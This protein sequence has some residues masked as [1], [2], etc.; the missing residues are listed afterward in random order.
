[1]SDDAESCRAIGL[2]EFVGHRPAIETDAKAVVRQY[3]VH[4]GKG[5]LQPFVAIVIGHDTSVT[6]F[7]MRDVRWVRQDEVDASVV[8]HRQGF[9]AIGVENFVAK[10]GHSGIPYVSDCG[11]Y[12]AAHGR[13][14]RSE[15]GAL[16]VAFP[17]EAVPMLGAGLHQAAIKRRG[18]GW[19]V[20]ANGRIRHTVFAALP[21]GT[22]FAGSG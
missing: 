9:E 14:P 19:I 5:G 20:D 12:G 21:C 13:P 22:N 1:M 10:N 7:V 15:S 2:H 3:P 17:D 11:R 16:A 18:E 8:E 4:L 6:R